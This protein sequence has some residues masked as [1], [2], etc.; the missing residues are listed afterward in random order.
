[1]VEQPSGNAYLGR[2]H[3]RFYHR[4]HCAGV[5]MTKPTDQD[6][7]I[8]EAVIREKGS[9]C[10]ATG[11]EVAIARRGREAGLL[12]AKEL[13]DAVRQLI[14]EATHGPST[15]LRDALAALREVLK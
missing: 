8:A 3:P 5:V 11:L 7:E 14:D 4:V 13:A 2:R 15:E 6:R 9:Q 10:P 1:M 12:K